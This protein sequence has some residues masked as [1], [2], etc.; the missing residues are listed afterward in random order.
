MSESINRVKKA[1]EEIQKGNIIIMIDDE[2]RENEGDLVYA[3]V[4][5]SPQKVN[6]L[7]SEGKGL[8]CVSLTKEIANKLNLTPMVPQNSESFSTAFTISV[9]AKECK[10]GISAYERDLTVKKLSSPITKPD[11]LVRPGHI[12]PLIAK[13][14]GVLVRTGHTEGSVDICKLAGLYPVAVICEIMKEDGT[15]ARRDDLKE[16]A[17]KHNLAIVY[18]SDIVEYRLQF[19]SLVKIEKKENITIHGVDFEKV[20]FIDHLGNR[21]YVLANNPKETTNVKFYQ[22]M[23]NVDFLLN[24]KLVNEYNKILE[25]IKYNSGVIV[26]INSTSN[27]KNK[28]FG[29]G[30]QI[31]KSLGIKNLN[32]FSHHKNEL[33]A[34]KGFGIHIN[35]YLE[36]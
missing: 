27:D 10:T 18:I 20:T 7:A 9:D 34:L 36:I 13:D 19:E 6:F 16:F 2:D 3:G 25:Y 14:G 26:F 29:I 23:S 31:L 4:F 30:A 11:D 22:V 33:N 8:I 17:K 35:K 12:F 21:H 24:E 5:S 15:M 32:L 28:E 1:I